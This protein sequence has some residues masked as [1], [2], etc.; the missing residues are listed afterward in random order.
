M[1]DVYYV[2]SMSHRAT[3]KLKQ[4]CPDAKAHFVIEET[5]GRGKS[6]K[7]Y[8]SIPKSLLD[9]AIE[10]RGITRTS[11]NKEFTECFDWGL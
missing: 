10:I 5:L 11:Q 4:L 7:G 3:Q 6:H 8:Y 2:K 9:K 1:N